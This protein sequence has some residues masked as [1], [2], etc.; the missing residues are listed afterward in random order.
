[1][2]ILL[3]SMIVFT[4]V[5]L[6]V[7]Q[8]GR[9][10]VSVP[11]EERNDV[12]VYYNDSEGRTTTSVF[13]PLSIEIL[14]ESSILEINAHFSHP[15]RQPMTPKDVQVVFSVPCNV[16]EQLHPDPIICVEGECSSYHPRGKAD[17][18]AGS[19]GRERASRMIDLPNETFLKIANG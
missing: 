3:T 18:C 11:P 8:D 2:K 14:D 5:L 7:A 19:L 15:G 13:I 16:S 17:F 1:M 6:G 9:V 4:L 10:R 12:S